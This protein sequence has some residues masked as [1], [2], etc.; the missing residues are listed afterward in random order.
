MGIALTRYA[1]A[2]AAL[3]ARTTGG[4][5]FGLDTTRALLHSLGDP[6]E[7]FP[8]FHIG[9]TNGKGSTTHT[10]DAL[11]RA[12][13]MRVGRYTSPHLVDFRERIVV[14]GAPIPEDAVVDW[15]ARWTPEIE[16]TGATFFEA[17]TCL[18]FDWFARSALDVAVIEVGLGG[19]LDATNLITPMVA[20]V[21][22]IG[23]E[24]TEYLGNTLE[25]I[26][27]E[28]S[29]IFKAGVAAVISDRAPAVR[30]QMAALA[31]AA[32]ASTVCVVDDERPVSDVLVGPHGT[33]FTMHEPRA[34]RWLTTPLLG[35]FQASNTAVAL[36]ML[37]QAGGA[38]AAASQAADTNLAAVRVPGRFERRGQYLFDVAHNPDSARV[39]A[40]LIGRVRPPRPIR[41][42]FAVLDDKDWRSMMAH[43]AP[44][45][46]EFVLTIAPSAP[47]ER[48]WS[49]DEAVA[50]A[51]ASGWPSR[52][53]PDF[54]RALDMATS[55]AATTLV[56]G[57][58]HTVGD[59]MARLQIDPLAE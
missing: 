23:L 31:R 28:K 30:A 33:S 49:L 24:H 51:H 13:G 52:A 18:A 27:R 15:I 46:D 5:K 3:F 39:L 32:G 22:S 21:T 29:G 10:L 58:F 48:R 44:R 54:A 40:D 34:T 47:A 14:N 43:L 16:R 9:G 50:A 38:Y 19:R 42:L 25:S 37:E 53:E 36:T 6:H 55:D 57:S 1:A 20:A 2:L 26:A 7:R 35:D 4:W 17:T 8:S 59:A 41:A 12:E 45:V 11:L 56:T